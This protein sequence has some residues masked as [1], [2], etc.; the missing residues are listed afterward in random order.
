M[1]NPVHSGSIDLSIN[2]HQK[3]PIGKSA[4][5]VSSAGTEKNYFGG[6][7]PLENGLFDFFKDFFVH[8]ILLR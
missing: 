8:V 7:F 2:K 3:I 6:R 1:S 4:V 5:I